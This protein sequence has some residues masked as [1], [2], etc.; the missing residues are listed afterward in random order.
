HLQVDLGATFVAQEAF[1]FGHEHAPNSTA[2]VIRRNRQVVDP[3]P[4]ALV[5]DHNGS[6]DGTANLPDEKQV[7]PHFKFAT[8]ILSRVVPWPCELTPFPQIDDGLLVFGLIR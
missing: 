5:S 2:T 3:A 8:N 7:G 6:H 1:G 4:V